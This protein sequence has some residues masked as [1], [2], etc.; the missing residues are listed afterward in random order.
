VLIE[1]FLEGEE[2]SLLSIVSGRQILPLAPAQ[3]YKRALDG[4]AGPNTGGMGSYSPVPAMYEAL[5]RECVDLAVRP[6]V[7]ELARRGIDFRGVLYAGLML[8]KSGPKVLEYNCRFGDPETQAL[9]PRLESDLLE[10]LYTAATG[11]K[12][13]AAAAWR[14]GAAVGVVMASRGYP[15]SASKGDVITGLE[16]V[17]RGGQAEVFHAATKAVDGG[18]VTSGGRVLTVT[19]LGDSFAEARAR[20]YAGIADI[21]FPGEQHRTDIALRAEK[22]EAAAAAAAAA[23]A[24][25]PAGEGGER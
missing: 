4:D 23:A 20:A 18:V 15:A 8:T 16:R 19:G 7:D 5:Y 22:W 2:V 9:L 12:L 21:T 24:Q 14:L 3:D 13:P 6:T 17:R 10:L 1:E 11:G 25:A